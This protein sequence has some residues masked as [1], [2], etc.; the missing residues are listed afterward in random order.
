MYDIIVIGGGIVGSAIL[1]KLSHTDRKVLLLEKYDDVACGS[2]R[3]NSGIVHA[4]YDAEEGTNKAKFNVLGN[5][6]YFDLAKELNVPCQ[7]I[8]S[9]VLADREG[10]KDLEIL[11][12]RGKKNG[13]EGLRIVEKEELRRMEPNVSEKM[14]YGL[15]APSAGVV[16]PY[17]MTVA[18]AE[19]AVLNGAEIRFEE[20]VL[21]SEFSDG[22]FTVRTEKGT[23]ESKVLINCAGFGAAAINRDLGER[24]LRQVYKRGDYFILDNSER[25]YFRHTCFPLPTAAG[26][27]VLVSPTADGNVIVGPTSVPVESGT[28]T[29]VRA[30]GLAEIRR[31]VGKMMDNVNFSKGIRVFA[32]VRTSVEKDFVIENG[33]NPNFIMVAGICSPGLTAAP[34][35]AEYVTGELL[36][37]TDLSYSWKNS[38]IKRPKAPVTRELT[39]SQWKALIEKDPSY[40]R[41]V[42]RCEKITEGEILDALD[43]PLK[44]RSLDAL[45]RRVRTGM[46]RCQGGFCTP[47]IMEII[48]KHCGLKPEEITKSGKGSEI[49]IGNIKEVGDENGL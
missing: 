1:R 10:K 8:G 11:L 49:V 5:R 29:A 2:S 16:S 44:P 17:E 13:V 30:E 9:L 43:S 23:Y 15:Y 42:C 32:G 39:E 27:G 48:S 25:R 6:M 46:G 47:K 18:L 34:A 41:I 14:E 24:E 20:E 35:I 36:K 37:K 38:Y 22:K 4:G 19:Q 33:I 3:A 45:K 26:K 21:H 40:G 31:S 12:E 7:R 28:D